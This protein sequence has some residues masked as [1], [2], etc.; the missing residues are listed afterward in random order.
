LLRAWGIEPDAVIGHSVGELTAAVAAGALDL[1]RALHIA[2]QRGGAMDATRGAGTMLS[3]PLAEAAAL[4]L[5]GRLEVALDVAA[6]NAPGSCVLSGAESSLQRVAAEL[7]RGGSSVRWLPVDYPFHSRFMA[8]AADSLQRALVDEPGATPH[9]SFYSTVT[10][11]LLS[12]TVLDAGYWASNVRNPVR[13][14]DAVRA[15]AA[16]RIAVFVELSSHPALLG[17]IR[18]SVAAAGGDAAIVGTLGRELPSTLAMARCL[19]RLFCE[20][21]DPDWS[22]VHSDG[23]RA[24]RLPH[25]PW[26]HERY[27]IA[28]A[29]AQRAQPATPR[30]NRSLLGQQLALAGR[31]T[32]TTWSAL[33]TPDEPGYLGQH[34]VLGAPVLP[35]AAYVEL[36]LSALWELEQVSG[37]VV[38]LEVHAPLWIDRGGSELQTWLTRDGDA[39]RVEVHAR[40][41][42]GAEF[43]CHASMRLVRTR[44]ELLHSSSDASIAEIQCRCLEQFPIEAFYDRLQQIG[45]QYGPTF[46]GLKDLWRRDGE[47]LGTLQAASPALAAQ[48]GRVHPA[49]LDALFHTIAAALPGASMDGP[50]ALY[51]PVAIGSVEISDAFLDATKIHAAVRSDADGERVVAQLRALAPDGSVLATVDHLVLRRA[52]RADAETPADGETQAIWLYDDVWQPLAEPEA[53]SAGSSAMRLVVMHDRSRHALALCDALQRRGHEL[54]HVLA[55][56]GFAQL[57][58]GT[59]L[60]NPQR[61]EDHVELARRVLNSSQGKYDAIVYL[62]GLCDEAIADDCGDSVQLAALRSCM[63]LL[64]L[65]RALTLN[66]VS[67]APRLWIVTRGSQQSDGQEAVEAWQAPLWGLAKGISFEQPELRCT[68]LDL[69]AGAELGAASAQ[70][71]IAA[72]ERDGDEVELAVRETGTFAPRFVP[73]TRTLDGSPITLQPDAAYVVSGGLGALGGYVAAWLAACGAR[74]I[75]LLSRNSPPAEM[76][77]RFALMQERGVEVRA[78]E[79]DVSD[80]VALDDTL[81]RVRHEMGPIAGV[82]HAAGVLDDGA[83]IGLCSTRMASVFDP[84]VS[85]GFNLDRATRG[86]ALDF[87]VVFSSA[88]ASLGSVGQASY[89]AANAYLGALSAQ[90]AHEGRPVSCIEWGPWAGA[91]MAADAASGTGSGK[92]NAGISMIFPQDGLAVMEALISAAERRAIVLPFDL[93]S[94]VHLYPAAAG[95]SRFERLFGEDLHARRNA[96][97]S[98]RVSRRPDL[99]QAF[100]EPRNELEATI[101]GI[102]QRALEVDRVGVRDSFFELGGD[103][104]L[105]GQVV[106]QINMTLGVTLDSRRAFEAFTVEALS[107]NAEDAIQ[108]EVAKLSED[109]ARALL[110]GSGG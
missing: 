62:L 71:A 9:L 6:I 51:L 76:L 52:Q 89:I 42:G 110:S 94:L 70:R 41:A 69:P 10:G 61:A 82:V 56:E 40:P 4:A 16:D 67:A 53:R 108:R 47:A 37:A 30:R 72:I 3:V 93:R 84:K 78:L 81:E 65:S 102:W 7:E 106:T 105:A 5:A 11:G 26:S 79:V 99:D 73:S 63:P 28:P 29:P 58:S 87:F 20:G 22:A 50:S 64:H 66:S 17:A 100:V 103:S 107:A 92:R 101:A 91:G 104:V 12:G 46:R 36:G 68:R 74:H 32:D 97:V 33:I 13:F 59:Y 21:I 98:A 34:I 18:D 80:D 57:E 88:A 15:A 85:G 44:G 83:A 31:R 14:A 48:A 95:L 38:D 19:G 1:E 23:G 96:S 55:G 49:R 109:E 8:Q 77:E 35:A 24:L 86:D 39:L 90:R 27:W 2:S 60:L 43:V 75:A 45:L 25:F 54:T